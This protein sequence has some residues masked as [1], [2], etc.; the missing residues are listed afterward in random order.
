M[1]LTCSVCF[2]P[3]FLHHHHF[4]V[5]T[6][7]YLVRKTLALPVAVGETHQNE[8]LLC[9]GCLGCSPLMPMVAITVQSLSFLR[10]IHQTCPKFGLEAFSKALCH[11]HNVSPGSFPSC[12]TN[13][14]SIRYHLKPISKSNFPMRLT[15]TPL[16]GQE[17]GW[18]AWISCSQHPP[19]EM[20]SPLLLQASRWSEFRIFGP[21]FYGWK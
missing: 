5:P 7:F 13:T 11:L 9:N 15:F 12:H 14:A 21:R 20:L 10:H 3:S 17:T 4:T 18:K 6:L 1:L 8:T 2:Y 19:C 16:C